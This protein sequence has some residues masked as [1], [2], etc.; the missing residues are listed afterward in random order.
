MMGREVATVLRKV[1]T[2][3]K[4]RNRDCSGLSNG[5]G[6][7]AMTS[8]PGVGM[9]VNILSWCIKDQGTPGMLRDP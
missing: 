7:G 8:P 1:V 3:S 5:G 6:G 4:R 2:E 9:T